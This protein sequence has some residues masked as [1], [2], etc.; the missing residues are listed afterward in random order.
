MPLKSIDI[1]SIE[2]ESVELVGRDAATT[3]SLSVVP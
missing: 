1:V 2:R 3:S